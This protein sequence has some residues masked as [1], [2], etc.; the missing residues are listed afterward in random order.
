MNRQCGACGARRLVRFEGETFEIG[1]QAGKTEVP[2]LDGW[3]CAAC[4]EVSF[5]PDSARRYASAGDELVL[6]ARQNERDMIRRTRIRLG[7]TQEQA[8][9]LT[10]GGPNAF[11]RYERGKARPVT[12][13]VNLFRLL[14]A[15]P[16]LL[17]ELPL[18][19]DRARPAKARALN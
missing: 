5:D 2:G 13:V 1:H 12:A 19:A 10:G 15:H 3:R 6:Q 18:P 4:G 7:L 8:A 11:S 17:N 14:D 9:Y 16:E